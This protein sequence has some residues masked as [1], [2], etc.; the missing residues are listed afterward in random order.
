MGVDKPFLTY[1]EQLKKIKNDYNIKDCDDKKLEIDILKIYD[2]A[3]GYKELHNN[4]SEN[5]TLLDLYQFIIFDKKFQNILSLFSI[6]VE[7][8]FKTKLAYL[9]SY[10]RGLETLLTNNLLQSKKYLLAYNYPSNLL[11]RIQ[12]LNF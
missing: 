8:S 4:M 12:Q 3:N 11:D 2:L 5:I 1:E 10:T 6:Y 9:I 7:N